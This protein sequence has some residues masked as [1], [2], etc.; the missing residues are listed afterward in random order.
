MIVFYLAVAVAAANLLRALT[1]LIATVAGLLL[2][3]LPLVSVP[4]VDRW[5]PHRWIANWMSLGESTQFVA[6]Y[7]PRSDRPSSA[8]GPVVLSLAAV[9]CAIG[10]WSYLRATP[11]PRD[12]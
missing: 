12:E 4:G 1:P 2:L 6:Y 5:L 11:V 10:F 9:A 8:A 7:W 3:T